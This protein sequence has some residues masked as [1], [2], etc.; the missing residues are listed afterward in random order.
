MSGAPA[1]AFDPVVAVARSGEV[2][3]L[4]YD[5]RDDDPGDPSRLG[6][7]AWLARSRDGGATF[8]ETALDDLFDLRAAPFS[9]GLFLGDYQ[10]LA[11]AEDAFLPF[12]AR[13][14]PDG[15]RIVTVPW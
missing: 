2:A 7:R 11:A 4:Y 5:L 14:G 13:A 12:F 3:V 10:G 8:A 6:A 15:T 1:Q 9:G